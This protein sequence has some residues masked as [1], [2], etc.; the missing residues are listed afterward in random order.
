MKQRSTIVG[1]VLGVVLLVV[2]AGFA[3][4]LPKVQGSPSSDD[5]ASASAPGLPARV[6]ALYALDSDDLPTSLA[7]QI[8]S[9]QQ[10]V[11]AQT[12]AAKGLDKVFGAAAAYRIYASADGKTFVA[13]TVLD[14][15]AG[16]FSPDGPPVEATTGQAPTY[17]LKRIS[18]AVCAEYF[19]QQTDTQGQASGPTQLARAHC[20]LGADGRTYDIDARGLTPA[21]AVAALKVVARA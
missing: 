8:G 15:K 5:D 9:R 6:G 17:Q 7:Q 18:G 16:L 21:K 10:V 3:I 2:V 19:S 1:G 13:V 20:Q 12:D 14:R 4:F 11:K